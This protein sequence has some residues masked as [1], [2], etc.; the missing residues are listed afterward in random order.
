MIGLYYSEA[1]VVR[2]QHK[3]G[4]HDPVLSRVL[5]GDVI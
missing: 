4:F 1:P 2:C 5:R 3:L